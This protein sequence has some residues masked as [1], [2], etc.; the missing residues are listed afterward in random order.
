MPRC[1][2]LVIA[3]GLLAAALGL[4]AGVQDKPPQSGPQPTPRD[5]GEERAMGTIASVGVDRIE[6]KKMDGSAETVWV[7]D[8]THYRQGQQD[9]QMEDLKP[10]D[11]VSVRGRMNPQNEFVAVMVRRMTGEETG[12][13]QSA[14]DRVFGEIISIENNQLK[15]RNPRQGERIVLVSDQ[16]VLTKQGQPITLKDLKVGDHILAQGK[17]AEGKLA[18]TQISSGQW[19]GRGGARP[20]QQ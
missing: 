5:A 18:A 7:D 10:G 4:G 1:A 13:F 2:S 15:V 20:Q 12:R 6:I 17:E 14:G 19:Q 9:I 3:I 8:Q 16:T 11:R